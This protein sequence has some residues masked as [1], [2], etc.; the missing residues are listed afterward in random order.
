MG[1]QKESIKPAMFTLIVRVEFVLLL[2]LRIRVINFRLHLSEVIY[3]YRRLL[4]HT[5]YN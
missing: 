4:V 2:L 3:F 5:L 1:E